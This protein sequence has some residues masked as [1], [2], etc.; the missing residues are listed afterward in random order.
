MQTILS[1]RQNGRSLSLSYFL[2]WSAAEYAYV[3]WLTEWRHLPRG[4]EGRE[5]EGREEG[6]REGGHGMVLGRNGGKAQTGIN[7]GQK[8]KR[9]AKERLC[10]SVNVGDVQD[11]YGCSY[12]EEEKEIKSEVCALGQ[13]MQMCRLLLPDCHSLS[14]T[15]K[16][17]NYGLGCWTRGVQVGETR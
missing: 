5:S 13:R 3:A 2:L 17:T 16:S 1:A 6:R 14:S 10:L 7:V 9:Q 11:V 8:T 4:G 12:L 15:R